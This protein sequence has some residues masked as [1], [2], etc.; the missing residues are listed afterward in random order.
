MRTALLGMGLYLLAQLPLWQPPL[1][2]QCSSRA[3]FRAQLRK[4]TAPGIGMDSVKLKP[5]RTELG[6]WLS[7]WRKCYPGEDSSYVDALNLLSL[8]QTYLA[9]TS[10]KSYAPALD[11]AQQ[12]IRVYKHPNLALRK[13]DLVMS[14]FRL[15]VAYHYAEESEKSIAALAAVIELGKNEPKA[16]KYV[17]SAY[18]YIVFHYHSAGDYQK[19]LQYAEEGE[20]FNYRVGNDAIT[21]KLLEQKGQALSQLG[22]HQEAKR[23]VET[24]IAL[25]QKLPEH[26]RALTSGEKLLAGILYEMGRLD[27]SLLHYHRAYALAQKHNDENLSDYATAL[28]G[29]Y[30]DMGNDARALGYF[31]EALKIDRSGFSKS[32]LLDFLGILRRKQKD[33]ESALKYHQQGL[34]NLSIGYP[35]TDVTALPPARL[36]RSE[37]HQDYFLIIVQDKADTWLEYAKYQGNDR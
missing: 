8:V 15:G 3:A 19:A 27:E 23:A 10:N 14:Y 11:Y 36:I 32:I 13:S 31:Q 33:F 26:H 9:Y 18:P 5:Q 17:S 28:G 12:A 37:A 30:L 24:A 22:R 1:Y 29:V 7:N 35:E 4:I 34:N 20:K 6:I 2:A 16:F 25:V 21:A